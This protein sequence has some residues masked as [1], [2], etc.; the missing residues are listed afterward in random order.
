MRKTE[1]ASIII[2]KFI[3]FNGFLFWCMYRSEHHQYNYIN[4]IIKNNS[5]K[6]IFNL[7]DKKD[8]INI[9]TNISKM[10]GKEFPD[11]YVEDLEIQNLSRTHQIV[12]DCIKYGGF[13]LLT[14]PL[15]EDI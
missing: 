1:N 8:I 11:L 2:E 7:L 6:I 3:T 14:Q 9:L 10:L 5:D 15:K 4:V 12:D 13:C